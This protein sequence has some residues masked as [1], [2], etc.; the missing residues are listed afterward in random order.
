MVATTLVG[1]PDGERESRCD[2]C[3]GTGQITYKRLYGRS[4]RLDAHACRAC[5]GTGRANN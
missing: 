2:R 1:N 4:L 3:G 5:D